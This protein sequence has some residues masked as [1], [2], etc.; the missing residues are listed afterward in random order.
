MPVQPVGKRFIRPLV[1]AECQAGQAVADAQL[2]SPVQVA[3]AQ[4]TL[5]QMKGRGCEPRTEP[6]DFP[7]G[8]KEDDGRLAPEEVG[9]FH[10]LAEV[11]QVRTANHA[12]VLTVI[13]K[14]AGDRVDERA[15]PAAE[16]RPAFQ[17]SDSQSA[18]H[19]SRRD[20]QA[21]QAA[22]N[23]YH[24]RR[25]RLVYRHHRRYREFLIQGTSVWECLIG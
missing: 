2:V 20:G 10:P 24:M 18:P 3:G 16:P 17:K 19:Q 21:S 14:F 4:K 6:R 23:N 8:T 7:L 13:H 11:C 12:D 22:T 25:G 5:G 1:A 15:G 9:Y